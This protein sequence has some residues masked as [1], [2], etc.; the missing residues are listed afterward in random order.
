MRRG[1]LIKMDEAN[2]QDLLDRQLRDAVPYIDDAGFTARVMKQ[3][4]RRRKHR[5][6]V[7]A[8]ILLVTAILASGLSFVLSG[9]ARFI[10]IDIERVA[11]LPVQ[12]V[13]AI[14]V[15]SGLL[16]TGLGLI[17]AVFKTRELQ[18]N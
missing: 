16:L 18:S 8:T 4:P 9:N 14:A 2:Q 10:T 6:A 12:W 3:L 17:A 7:R 11:N 15:A 1:H 13:F 5:Q